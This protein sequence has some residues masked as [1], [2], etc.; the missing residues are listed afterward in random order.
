MS[1][2][3]INDEGKGKVTFTMLQLKKT[4]GFD[5]VSS[6]TYTYTIDKTKSKDR[7]Y[8]NTNMQG[9]IYLEN[10]GTLIMNDVSRNERYIFDYQIR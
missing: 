6:R 7:L 3:K 9:E 5:I 4:G 2:N 8:F 1:F 10:D